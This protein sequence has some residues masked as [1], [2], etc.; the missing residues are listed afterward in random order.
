MK[1]NNQDFIWAVGAWSALHKV[2]FDAQLLI[3]NFIPPYDITSLQTALQSYGFKIGLENLNLHSIHPAVFPVLVLLKPET[4]SDTPQADQAEAPVA[5]VAIVL[6]FDNDR[7]LWIKPEAE[8]PDV[9]AYEQFEALVTGQVLLASKRTDNSNVADELTSDS[10]PTSGNKLSQSSTANKPFGFKWFI[11]ELAKHK[12]VW[13]EILLASLAIQI[14]ALATPL[15]TQVII[16]KVVVHHTTSTLIV[17][18]IAL[19]IFMVFNAVMSWVRQYLVL[20]T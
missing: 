4:D 1:L 2:P 15:G 7:V 14:V 13:R 17:V 9:I 16:D 5:K 18:A 12:K 20:H 10:N 6:K 8:Q 19:G 11:P 3:R